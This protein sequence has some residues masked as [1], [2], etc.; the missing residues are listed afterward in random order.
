MDKIGIQKDSVLNQIIS[1]IQ[2]MNPLFQFILKDK[3]KKSEIPHMDSHLKDLIFCH[4][5]GQ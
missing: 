4:G 3:I 2:V 5:T 1:G